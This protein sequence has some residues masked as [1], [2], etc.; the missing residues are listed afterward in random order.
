M[1]VGVFCCHPWYSAACATCCSDCLIHTTGGLFSFFPFC[2]QSSAS[3]HGD[4]GAELPDT[5]RS[6]KRWIDG[7]QATRMGDREA[8]ERHILLGVSGTLTA[9]STP[10]VRIA[11]DGYAASETEGSLE[12]FFE[13]RF[14]KM[15]FYAT[16]TSTS[17]GALRRLP[18]GTQGKFQVTHLEVFSFL[19]SDELNVFRKAC[20][21]QRRFQAQREL[22]PEDWKG[23]SPSQQRN[24][25][26]RQVS[27]GISHEQ[28]S[29]L[30]GS[31]VT[32]TKRTCTTATALQLVEVSLSVGFSCCGQGGQSAVRSVAVTPSRSASK[33]VEKRKLPRDSV[34]ETS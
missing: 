15:V 22:Q 8:S 29:S 23:Q 10:S 2:C 14:L 19:D 34:S 21:F 6:Q 18:R 5:K 17:T 24:L 11:Y 28:K 26:K 4:G 25:K 16:P 12:R 13:G 33:G 32:A 9:V 1:D 31:D 27:Q 3:W 7:D 30:H 20:R